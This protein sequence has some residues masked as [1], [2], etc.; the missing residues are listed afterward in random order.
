LDRVR[1]AKR[2]EV[3][4]TEW[5]MP[6]TRAPSATA[7][8][9]AASSQFQTHL[10]AALSELSEKLRLALLLSAMD[11]HSLEEVSKILQ[12][13]VGTVKSRIFS[14]RKQLAEKLQCHVKLTKMR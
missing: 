7:E 12:V 5:S 11:G 4:E 2:R 8:D 3:R 10:D 9:L 14:A 1:S 6:A 13:P